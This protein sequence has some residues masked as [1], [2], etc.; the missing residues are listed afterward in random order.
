MNKK[1]LALVTV[2][3]ALL[4][5]FT[6]TGLRSWRLDR[7]TGDAPAMDN[8]LLAQ[9][10]KHN[11]TTYLVPPNE[12]YATGLTAEQVPPLNDPTYVSV[13]EADTMLA[14]ELLG[15]DVEVGGVHYFYPYQV[16]NWH[17]VANV[18]LGETTLAIT[19]DPLTGSAVVFERGNAT[20]RYSG[21]VYNN[22]L[23]MDDGAGNL[24]LQ[25][26]GMLVVGDDAGALLT[27]YP[28]QSMTWAAWKTAYADGEVLGFQDGTGKDYRMYPYGTYYT[29]KKL[30]F[31]VNHTDDRIP[32][33][34]GLDG[35]VIGN[36]SAVFT[37][38]IMEQAGVLNVTVGGTPLV[39]LNDA[40]ADVTNVFDARVGTSGDRTLTFVYNEEDG[41]FT[42]NETQ[43]T[44]TAQGL[45]TKGELRG[46][47]LTLVHAPEAYWFAWIAMHPHSIL[48]GEEYAKSTTTTTTPVI[49]I[50]G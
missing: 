40:E 39:A 11:G 8:G 10:Q 1:T 25:M 23:L 43:S 50:G 45:A 22:N 6:L 34:D 32:V 31:P 44:W 3:M 24:W 7:A 47:Q 17:E 46:A 2:G 48:A 18:T 12:V 20:F 19:Y 5:F 13:T 37:R 42:D 33:K 4:V 35:V 15:I 30:Y 16:L 41:V 28:S 14:D 38:Y 21:K 36:E 49:E 26:R 9:P 27:Q 29:S